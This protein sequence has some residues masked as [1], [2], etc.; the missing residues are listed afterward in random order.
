MIAKVGSYLYEKK[1]FAS[2]SISSDPSWRLEHFM[3]F[4]K[5]GENHE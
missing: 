5:K 4:P 2:L 1:A 3:D